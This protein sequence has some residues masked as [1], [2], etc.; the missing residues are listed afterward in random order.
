VLNGGQGELDL[1]G[2]TVPAG[3]T[4]TTEVEVRAGQASVI[5]PKNAN[6][7]VTCS[8][9]A[10]DIDCLGNVESGLKKQ[11]SNTQDGSSDQGEINL[12]VHVGAGQAEVRN[13]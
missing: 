5:V 9:N 3:E 6:V 13:G 2:F 11:T 7:N 8:A 12:N 4:V 10:G 1:R